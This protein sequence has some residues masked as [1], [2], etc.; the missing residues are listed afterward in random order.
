MPRKCE[1]LSPVHGAEVAVLW[2][3]YLTTLNYAFVHK[4]Q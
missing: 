4:V 3:S 1:E 2:V